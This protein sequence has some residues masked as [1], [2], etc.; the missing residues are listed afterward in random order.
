MK[1]R[2]MS[3]LHLEFWRR[4]KLSFQVPE[5]EKDKETVLVLAGDIDVGTNAKDFVFKMCDRFLAVIYVPGNHEYYGFNIDRVNS[6]IRKWETKKDNFHFL[7]PGTVII[8]EQLFVGATLWT[9]MYNKDPNVELLAQTNMNDFQYITYGRNRQLFRPGIWT[10][11][12][13]SHKSFFE[14][15]IKPGCVVI[16]HHGPTQQSIADSFKG[17]YR[18]IL[19]YAYADLLDDFILETEPRIWIHGHV[20]HT[21]NYMIG[22]TNVLSNP[23][24]YKMIEENHEFDSERSIFLL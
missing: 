9:S 19:N 22:K 4:K 1:I 20:H 16:S 8:N 12:H 6:K 2:Y 14:D 18:A 7:N 10:T 3:D 24:G 23:Y 21:N 5:S 11:I 17:G 15:N 13:A